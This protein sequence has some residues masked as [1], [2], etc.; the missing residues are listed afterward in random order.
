MEL[1]ELRQ[2]LEDAQQSDEKTLRLQKAVEE[3]RNILPQIEIDRHELQMKVKQAEFDKDTIDER[4]QAVLEQHTKDQEIIAEL[5]D[6]ALG[7][8]S[9]PTAASSNSVGLITELELSENH[10]QQR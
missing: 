2:Q 10:E 5:Q 8:E 7:L 9:P 6:R 3:Y 1:D 4:Y